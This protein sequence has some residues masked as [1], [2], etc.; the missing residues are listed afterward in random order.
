MYALVPACTCVFRRLEGGGRLWITLVTS[1][2]PPQH[3]IQQW[4]VRRGRII[5]PVYA[6][7]LSR[8]SNRPR[9]WQTKVIHLWKWNLKFHVQ[10]IFALREPGRKEIPLYQVLMIIFVSI[11]YKR[12][13]FHTKFWLLSINPLNWKTVLSQPCSYWAADPKGTMSYWTE[14]RISV[15]PSNTSHKIRRTGTS[16]LYPHNF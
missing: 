10:W 15:H 8:S 7:R 2:K 3:F 5:F 11:G 4:Y 13:S 12:F 9:R 16:C 14:G 6:P 1:W